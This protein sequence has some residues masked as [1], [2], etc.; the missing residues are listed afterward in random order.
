MSYAYLIKYICLGYLFIYHMTR[1]SLFLL[2]SSIKYHVIIFWQTLVNQ[3]V[4]E[5]LSH[6]Q[7]ISRWMNYLNLISNWQDCLLETR[8]INTN[9][10]HFR[11]NWDPYFY[12]PAVTEI[13]FFSF[14]SYYVKKSQMFLAGFE[15]RSY[16]LSAQRPAD[17]ITD[18]TN[19]FW[20]SSKHSI[21][22]DIF[23]QIMHDVSESD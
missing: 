1:N 14:P 3:V 10:T 17:C 13:I 9:A 7:V 23:W 2:L 19:Q 18:T 20:F 5:W 22:G 12:M 21:N 4:L 6:D 16:R 11:I 15:P 8:S